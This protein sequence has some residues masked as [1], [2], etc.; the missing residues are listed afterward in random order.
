VL[1]LVV[2]VEAAVNEGLDPGKGAQLMD[3][4]AGIARQI[5][6]NAI[7]EAVAAG[8]NPGEIS[9]AQQ[10]LAD[11]DPLR[12]SGDFKDAVNKYKDALSKAESA[13]P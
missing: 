6:V 10:S 5:A 4:F 1:S 9:D 3:N 2:W 8:G 11:G 12:T 7:D 13:L